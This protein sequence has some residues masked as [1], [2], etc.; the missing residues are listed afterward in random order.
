MEKGSSELSPRSRGTISSFLGSV[1]RKPG[2]GEETTSTSSTTSAI[3]PRKSPLESSSSSVPLPS[4]RKSPDVGR[5]TAEAAFP[6]LKEGSTVG[7]SGW[8]RKKMQK[9][10][11][12]IV[13]EWIVWFKT[14]PKFDSTMKWTSA[15][16]STAKGWLFLSRCNVAK[17]EKPKVR[18]EDKFLLC[19]VLFFV[20]FFFFLSSSR[21]LLL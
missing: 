5:K 20:C 7:K 1:R 9:R 6:V 15:I 13:D 17:G 21:S 12:V 4:P 19:F 2:G 3:S 11:F 10:F 18:Q 8:L 14:E 16:Q